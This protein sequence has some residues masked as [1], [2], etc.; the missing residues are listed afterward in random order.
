MRCDRYRYPSQSPSLHIT[1]NTSFHKHLTPHFSTRAN[2][3][4]CFKE[5]LTFTF[6]SNAISQPQLLQQ[7]HH[8]DFLQRSPSIRTPLP[9]RHPRSRRVHPPLL[10]GHQRP[11]HRP[12][13]REERWL[14][15]RPRNL[16]KLL[17]PL[18]RRQQSPSLQPTRPANPRSR[19]RWQFSDHIADAEYP[20]LPRGASG[21]CT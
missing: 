15:D 20:D 12:C 21:S 1:S 14:Q 3:S 2:D 8:H 13:R 17:P 4:K 6:T 18:K 7:V 11:L 19:Q 10:R 16:H 9:P 5:E